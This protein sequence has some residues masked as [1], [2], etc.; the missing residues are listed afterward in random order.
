MLPRV[1]NRET[2]FVHAITAAGIT[3]TLTRNCSR[4]DFADCVCDTRPRAPAP[5]S[6]ELEWEMRGCSDNYNFGAQ[7][8]QQFLDAREN[9][10]DSASLANLHNNEAGRVVG[11]KTNKSNKST[12][13]QLVFSGSEKD[14]EEAVQMPWC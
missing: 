13:I 2:A 9:G 6:P 4:G 7:V 12:S 10:L 8:A 5:S 3:H 11:H 1:S 14:D